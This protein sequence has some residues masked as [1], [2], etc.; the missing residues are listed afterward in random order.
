MTGQSHLEAKAKKIKWIL[1]DNDGVLTEG[2]IVFFS[3]GG[4]A[5]AFDVKDGVGIKLAQRA[6]IK[7][8][9]IT[10]RSS[11]AVERRA[12]ELEVE[13]LHQGAREKLASYE[14]IL[15]KHSLQDEEVCFIGDDIIDI[16]VMKR[17]G[18]PVAV[19]DAH[20]AI[21]PFAVYQTNLK[22][23]Q[24]AVREVIDL[25]IKAQGKWDQLMKR[26]L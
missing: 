5:K 9:I 6:G 14:K 20:K 7:I 8:G 13:E 1:M 2:K 19:A 12:Q 17:A 24:G 3:G 21:L 16:P 23:G 26:Y 10:G 25:I 4:E 11:E 18:F 15:K 22:G